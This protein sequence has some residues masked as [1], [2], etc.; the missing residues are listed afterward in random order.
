MSKK[1]IDNDPLS[2]LSNGDEVAGEAMNEPSRDIEA[3]DNE[4]TENK[5]DDLISQAETQNSNA[6]S[7][8]TPET[9]GIELTAASSEP[10]DHIN[11]E[12]QGDMPVIDEIEEQA[13]SANDSP[14]E[15]ESSS[16]SEP[17]AEMVAEQIQEKTEE[18][19]VMATSSEANMVLEEDI[20]ISQVTLLKEAWLPYLDNGKNLTI[21]ASA[22][23]DIDT[24]GLQLLL[25]FVKTVNEAGRSVNWQQPSETLMTAVKETSLK[26]ALGVTEAG[27]TE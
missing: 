6:E 23:D 5:K 21:D 9:P 10:G 25:S 20:S 22:V 14:E 19:C 15:A 12:Q 16:E 1:L 18:E 13:M 26:D 3:T 27:V 11:E 7:S 2:W 8:E 17:A 24:A 4:A